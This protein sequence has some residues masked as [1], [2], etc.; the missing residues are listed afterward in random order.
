MLLYLVRGC[1]Q[2]LAG[3]LIM[4]YG[5]IQNVTYDNLHPYT[6]TRNNFHY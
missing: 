3:A 6:G 2:L 1:R 5:I 4:K